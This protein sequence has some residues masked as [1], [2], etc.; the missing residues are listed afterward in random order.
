[1]YDFY[2]VDPETAFRIEVKIEG[3]WNKQIEGKKEYIKGRILKRVVDSNSTKY[4]IYL[5][6]NNL[7]INCH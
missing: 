6:Y 3:F 7:I 2:R 4:N 1:L 5:K